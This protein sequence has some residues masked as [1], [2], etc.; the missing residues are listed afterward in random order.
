MTD[1]DS[2]LSFL[3]M[4]HIFGR[5]TEEFALSCG[6]S[7]GYWQVGTLCCAVLRCAALRPCLAARPP[8]PPWLGQAQQ[9]QKAS[10]SWVL[11]RSAHGAPGPGPSGTSGRARNCGC[12]DPGV[13]IWTTDTL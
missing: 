2:V 3:T 10:S 13:R 4:A 12:R 7:L 1:S 8:A 9:S 5:V 6:A 11:R